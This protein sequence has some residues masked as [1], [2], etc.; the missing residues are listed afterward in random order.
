MIALPVDVLYTFNPLNSATPF[1][2]VLGVTAAVV[3]CDLELSAAYDPVIGGLI[4]LNFA[5]RK[6]FGHK[7]IFVSL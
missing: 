7:Y 1:A 6:I 5:S 2:L 3:S 4:D